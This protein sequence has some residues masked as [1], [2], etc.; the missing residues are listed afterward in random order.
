MTT[1]TCK[2]EDHLRGAIEQ[3]WVPGTVPPHPRHSVSRSV[4]VLLAN[5]SANTPQNP[6]T[7]MRLP[8]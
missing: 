4:E 2:S 6:S 3:V 8:L 7:S 5:S 1:E